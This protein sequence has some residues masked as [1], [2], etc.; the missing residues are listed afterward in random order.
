MARRVNDTDLLAVWQEA[1]EDGDGLRHLVQHVLERVL[2]EEL[3]AFLGA[4]T[5]ERTEGRRGYRNGAKPR[6]LK[7]RVGSI[8]LMVPKDREG[9]FQPSLFE[10]YQRNEKAL[11][12]AL[13]EMYVQGV[14]TRKVKAI[15]EQLCGLEISKS[16]VSALATGLDEAIAAWRERPLERAYPYLIVDARYEKVRCGPRVVSQ[17]VLVVVGISAAGF[18]EILGV[19][20]AATESEAT[21]SEVFEDL[22]RRGL[23][24]VQYVVSDDHQ[25]L[26]RAIDRHFQGALWQRCQV[27]FLRNLLGRVRK[28]DRAEVLALLRS[29]TEAATREA[30]LEAVRAAVAALTAT[31]PEVAALLEAAAPEILAVYDLPEAHRKRLRSTNLLERYNQELKRRTRV[32]RIFP[33]GASC[34]RLVSALAME[35]NEEWL[36]RRYLDM[37]GGQTEA[38]ASAVA[39]RA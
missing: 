30:A 16:Q 23:H 15:T 22:K 26:R 37:E 13:V 27:H 8:D 18:R 7:T 2:E 35:A 24:G 34:V 39:T 4:E 20:Q 6:T 29:I 19:W 17:G 25:G 28:R 1:A 10:R 21:W 33:N 14:S 38:G 31:Y 9:R 11:V 32:V 36:A 12:L 5:Y 3:T